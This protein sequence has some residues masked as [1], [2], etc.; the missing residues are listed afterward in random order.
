MTKQEEEW[1]S[2]LF[3]TKDY[4][5]KNREVTIQSDDSITTIPVPDDHVLCNGCNTNIYPENSWLMEYKDGD[6]WFTYDI[7]CFECRDKYFPNS[8]KCVLDTW[9]EE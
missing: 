2:V 7:Y 3:S 1:R 8:K 5:Y 4:A 9:M 6:K